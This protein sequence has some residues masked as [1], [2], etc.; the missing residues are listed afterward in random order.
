MGK[1]EGRTSSFSWDCLK[2]PPILEITEDK[3]VWRRPLPVSSSF[4][5]HATLNLFIILDWIEFKGYRIILIKIG[6]FCAL[7]GMELMVIKEKDVKTLLCVGKRENA[8]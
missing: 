1:S 4:L 7:L 2:T 5:T 3:N 8:P 6:E